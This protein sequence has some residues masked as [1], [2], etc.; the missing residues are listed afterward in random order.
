MCCF[1]GF[2]TNLFRPHIRN[3]SQSVGIC[4]S[5]YERKNPILLLDA[6]KLCHSTTFFCW[7][8]L[9]NFSLFEYMMQLGNLSYISIPHKDYPHYL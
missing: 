1:G 6:L 3:P 7:P 2:D 4:S 5:F 9:E 8:Q